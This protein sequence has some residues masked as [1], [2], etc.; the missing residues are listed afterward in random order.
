MSP[1]TALTII[2]VLL[3]FSPSSHPL[4]RRYQEEDL[5]ISMLPLYDQL[6]SLRSGLRILLYSG[7]ADA[8]VPALGKRWL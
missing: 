4:T 6:L 5:Q 3:L 7:D 8:S 1:T 2:K